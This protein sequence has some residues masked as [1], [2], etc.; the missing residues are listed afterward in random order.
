MNHTPTWQAG[1]FCLA[2]HA[3]SAF[4]GQIWV[5]P[6][7]DD[8]A[9]GNESRPLATL[10]RA[11]DLARQQ[12]LSGQG[13][14]VVLRQGTYELDRPLELAAADS[15]S[16]QVPAVWRAATGEE[17][18]LSAGRCINGWQKVSD[19]RVLARLDPVAGSMVREIDLKASGVAEYGEM[20]GGFGKNGNPGLEL[21]VDDA[22]MHISRYP[23]EGFIP[24]TETLGPSVIDVRGTRGAKEGVFRVKDSRVAAW[25]QEKDPMAMGYWFWDWADGRQKIAAIDADTLTVTLSGPWHEYGYRK[26]QYFYGFNLLCEIDR[27]G[28]W[29]L[30]RE[31]GKLY[32]YLP[33]DGTPGRTM[34]SRLPRALKLKGSSHIILRDLIFEGARDSAV[35]LV[36]CENIELEGCI[37]RNSGKCGISVDGGHNCTIRRCEISGT[38]D[39]GV[40]LSGGDRATLAP[41]GHAVENCHIHAYSRWDRTYQPGISLNGVGCRASNNLIHDAPHQAISLSGNDHVIEYNEIHHVCEE[42]EDAGAIYGWNDWAARGNLIRFNYLHDVS[43]LHDKGA[44]GIYL[45]DNFSSARIEGNVFRRVVRAVHLGGGRD[46]EVTNNVFVDCAKALHVDA[47]GLG[48]RAF[49]FDEL[50]NKLQLWPDQKEPWS[51]RYPQIPS[52]LSDEP[53]APKGIQIS[54]NVLIGCPSWDDIESKARPFLTM[55]NNLPDAPRTLLAPGDGPPRINADAAEVSGIGFETIPTERIGVL[56]NTGR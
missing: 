46:H 39:G 30:D 24:I 20:S 44:N 15:G 45:D 12:I 11:R 49:G 42:T 1:V 41:S 52:I 13:V 32:A 9:P 22:P 19:E 3:A 18:R 35:S 5:S 56:R 55:K 16:A 6:S 23:N 14:E 4:A 28:E 17:V 34:V 25:A 43:G 40:R 26:G 2:M 47:R 53:M 29:Y 48:W 50:K 38:G 31:T 10:Q 54:R 51:T 8:D 7:G 21:F 36:D 37:V 27:P 33:G